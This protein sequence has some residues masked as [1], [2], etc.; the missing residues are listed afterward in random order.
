MRILSCFLIF[1]LSGCSTLIERTGGIEHSNLCT[2]IDELNKLLGKPKLVYGHNDHNLPKHIFLRTNN[3][4]YEKI[5]VHEIKGKVKKASDGVPQMYLA[6][7]TLGISE[8]IVVPVSTV[9]RISSNFE[10]H[11]YVSVYDEHGRCIL[12]EVYD[13]NGN[14]IMTGWY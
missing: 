9:K 5:L 2:S 12:S 11:D 13:T 14:Q 1:L 3:L 6:I 8:V 7:L 4:S 10:K